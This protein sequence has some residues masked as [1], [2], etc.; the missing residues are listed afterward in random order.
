MKG[1]F[2][3]CSRPCDKKAHL[4]ALPII[5]V[6]I[7]NTPA[8]GLVD[9]GCST[10]VVHSRYVPQCEG[11][12]FISAFDG[13]QIKC[14]GAHWVKLRVND[15][16]VTVRAVVSD[17]LVNGVDVVL[18]VD[19]IGQLG[20]VTVTQGKVCFGALGVASVSQQIENRPSV[21]GDES[22]SKVVIEDPDFHAMFDGQKWTVKWF[23][24]N[25]EPVTLTNKVSCY[26][27]KLEGW[28]KEEFEKE[29]DRW[30]AE[31]ILAPWKKEVKTG[32]I[33]LMAV[34]QPTKN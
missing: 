15:D 11:E 28:K 17:Q 13:S 12:I 30:I 18:G 6:L 32:I 22:C 33:P 5:D 7:G 34:E 25:N 8:R 2:C 31:G 27:K 29:V 4:N 19:V 26:N 10:S 14:K 24:K 9:T 1:D 23:W 3:A 21:E 16:H 20:G